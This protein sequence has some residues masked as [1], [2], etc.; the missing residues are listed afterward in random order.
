[1][2]ETDGIAILEYRRSRAVRRSRIRFRRSGSNW[3]ARGEHL[4]DG[5]LL[6][7]TIVVRTSVEQAGVHALSLR[8]PDDGGRGDT[9]DGADFVARRARRIES[10]PAAARCC[11]RSRRRLADRIGAVART[12]PAATIFPPGWSRRLHTYL[13]AH[14]GVRSAP[15]RTT[16]A[17]PREIIAN[18]R[19][20]RSATNCTACA[21]P[22]RSR[23]VIGPSIEGR[24]AT[25]ESKFHHYSRLAEKSSHHLRC[26]MSAAGGEPLDFVGKF[27]PLSF[28][29]GGEANMLEAPSKRPSR[30][31]QSRKEHVAN[32]SDER[33]AIQRQSNHASNFCRAAWPRTRADV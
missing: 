33:R 17:H 9:I 7:A 16:R 23:R 11:G 32:H 19:I 25:V 22:A 26:R 29:L 2:T 4:F 8:A 6:H 18:R 5:D 1:M 20:F 21:L 31:E 10:R 12:I 27:Y 15:M 24:G 13:F 28:G 30:A 3:S 14:R